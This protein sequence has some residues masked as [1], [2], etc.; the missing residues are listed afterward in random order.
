MDDRDALLGGGARP[1]EFQWGLSQDYPPMVRLVDPGRDVD[2]GALAGPVLADQRV[3][4][5]AAE[6]EVS[7]V[8]RDDSAEHLAD[9]PDLED[10]RRLGI[11]VHCPASVAVHAR[12]PKSRHLKTPR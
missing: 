4:L 10:G 2:E 3:D 9:G 7:L 1:A 11:T 6:P 5:A 12:H 8:K